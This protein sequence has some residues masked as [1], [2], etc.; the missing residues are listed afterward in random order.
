MIKTIL[1]NIAYTYY[2]KGI[3]NIEENEKYIYSEEFKRLL[4]VK[5]TFYQMEDNSKQIKLLIDKFLK[6]NL[7][8]KIQDMTS[9]DF[10]RCLSFEIEIV[11]GDNKLIKICLNISLLIPYYI[12]Y[13]LEN[14]IQLNPYKWI[15]LPKRIKE[16]EINQYKE[17]LETI[18]SIVEEITMFN[19]FPED[20][21]NTI[22]P[23][24]AFQDIRMGSFTFFNA[25]FQE[26][27]L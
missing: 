11:E 2:P 15:T 25:F 14:E 23:D 19:K 27:K 22:I 3:D 5:S 21:A 10:D 13:I 7:T 8:N 16:K 9:F 18:S 6:N 12:V 24:L 4:F 1:K 26:K 20:I 17:H